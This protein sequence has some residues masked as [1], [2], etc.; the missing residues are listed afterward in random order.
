MENI[1]R[2]NTTKRNKK[3]AT[4]ND[5]HSTGLFFASKKEGI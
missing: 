5:A 4:W 2:M 1:K 3:E